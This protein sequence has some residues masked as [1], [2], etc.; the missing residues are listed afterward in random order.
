MVIII[1]FLRNIG[2]FCFKNVISMLWEFFRGALYVCR[3]KIGCSWR[4][5]TTQE[6]DQELKWKLMTLSVWEIWVL[7]FL[8]PQSWDTSLGGLARPPPSP[9]ARDST[10]KSL[11]LIGLR[12]NDNSKKNQRHWTL[13][14]L[15]SL[16]SGIMLTNRTVGLF[17]VGQVSDRNYTWLWIPQ[18]WFLFT[19]LLWITN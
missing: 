3:S 16:L 9:A 13:R 2:I 5:Y 18:L 15:L 1:F 14:V 7:E 11:H 6:A 10:S 4:G 17:F 12:N 19:Y 8:G